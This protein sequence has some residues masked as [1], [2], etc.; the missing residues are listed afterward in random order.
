MVVHDWAR[1]QD[2]PKVHEIR[3]LGWEDDGEAK[4]MLNEVARQVRA[5][6]S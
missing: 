1:A 5:C 2:E 6:S 4:R 3:T